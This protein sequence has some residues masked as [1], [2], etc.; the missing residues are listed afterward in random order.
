MG[1]GLV[2]WG[3]VSG[4]DGEGLVR[5]RVRVRVRVWVSV[6]GWR[7]AWDTVGEWRRVRVWVRGDDVGHTG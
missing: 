6:R 4:W 2:M 3:N 1:P 7:R 5:A